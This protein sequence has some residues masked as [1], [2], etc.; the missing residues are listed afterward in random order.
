VA[1]DDGARCAV[2][3]VP[4]PAPALPTVTAA[5]LDAL[6]RARDGVVVVDVREPAE[7]AAGAIP[8]AVS[9]PLGALR[10]GAGLA[11]VPRDVPVVLHCAGGVRSSEALRLVLESGHGRASHLEGGIHAWWAHQSTTTGAAR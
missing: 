10:T 6:L 1:V 7:H 4:A 11:T 5:E 2:P 9:V 3:G 8:G